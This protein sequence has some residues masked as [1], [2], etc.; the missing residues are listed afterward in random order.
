MLLFVRPSLD[1]NVSL[2][3]RR[4]T[5]QQGSLPIRTGGEALTAQFRRRLRLYRRESGAT[6]AQC[7]L[8][9]PES[10]RY[11]PPERGFGGCGRVSEGTRTPDRLDHNQELYQLSYAHQGAPQSSNGGDL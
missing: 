11:I 5:L 4:S 3:T 2:T 6:E 10:A 8:M 1:G 9:S 7:R